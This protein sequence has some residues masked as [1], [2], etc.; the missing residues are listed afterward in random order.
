MAKKFKQTYTIEITTNEE[1][2]DRSTEIQTLVEDN[3]IF[4]KQ[5]INVE[6]LREDEA[7]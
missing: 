4:E 6:L 5:E 3:P 7:C 2:I 1:Y